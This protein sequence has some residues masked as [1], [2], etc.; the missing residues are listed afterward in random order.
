VN[1]CSL[2]A[3]STTDAQLA[4]LCHDPEG[5]KHIVIF[6]TRL[7]TDSHRWILQAIQVGHL[8][9]HTALHTSCSTQ[10]VHL[11]GHQPSSLQDRV[12]R[13]MIQRS[14]M[15]SDAH[16]LLLLSCTHAPTLVCLPPHRLTQRAAG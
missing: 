10:H 8:A 4:Y 15:C 16:L 11:H 3:A 2:E 13:I 6:V 7:L 1:V 12:T 5:C 14:G 9:Q